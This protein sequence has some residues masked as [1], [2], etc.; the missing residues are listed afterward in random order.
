MS[1]RDYEEKEKLEKQYWIFENIC[2]KNK[3]GDLVVTKDTIAVL[4]WI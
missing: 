4:C 1:Q 3:V 2:F